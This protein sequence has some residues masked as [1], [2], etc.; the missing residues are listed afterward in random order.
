M[1]LFQISQIIFA[2]ALKS[3]TARGERGRRKKEIPGKDNGR[4]TGDEEMKESQQW[5]VP[6]VTSPQFTS[7]SIIY[8]TELVISLGLN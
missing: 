7:T 8:N 4:A 2:T 3:A 1:S 6:G 5:D